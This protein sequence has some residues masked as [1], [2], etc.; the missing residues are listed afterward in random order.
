MAVDQSASLHVPPIASARG[1]LSPF[2]FASSLVSRVLE[3]AVHDFL[4]CGISCGSLTLV[5]NSESVVYGESQDVAIAARHPV[6]VV[7]ILNPESFY[8]RIAASADVGFAEAYIAKDFVV[9]H[10]DVLLSIFDILIRN[11]DRQ[12]LSASRLVVSRVGSFVNRILHSFNANSLAGSQRNI[13]AHYDISNSLFATFLGKSWM[14]SSAYF[15]DGNDNCLDAAQNE[16]LDMIIR[17]ARLTPD[18][19]VLEVGCGWGE[20]AIRAT[21]QSGCRVTGITLSTEQLQLARKRAS[22]AGVSDKVSF[23]LLDYRQLP[24]LAQLFDR[25]ISIEMLEAVGHE[26]LSTYFE[27][28][29]AVLKPDG[30]V[31]IQVITTPEERYAEYRKSTDFIQKHIFP[32]GICPSVHAVV[33]AMT[34]GSTLHLEHAENIGPHYATTLREWRRRFLQSVEE[35]KVQAAGFDDYFIRKWIYYFCYCEAGFASRTLG[36][37]QMVLSRAG[38]VSSLGGPPKLVM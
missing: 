19:H 22:D 4:S 12:Q 14:Y 38:N 37:M 21:L 13:K 31:V 6:A 30:L 3:Y 15:S 24:A 11:R 9:D 20:F 23:E 16:K 26:F 5:A 33:N 27:V 28:L 8:A 34:A 25:I 1:Q 10:P 32:G 35:K 36:N 7:T 29:D 17:K 18:C 2:A